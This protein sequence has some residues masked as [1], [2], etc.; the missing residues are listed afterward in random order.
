MHNDPGIC[1]L[2]WVGCVHS[3][4]VLSDTTSTSHTLNS[5]CYQINTLKHKIMSFN[6]YI[7]IVKYSLQNFG[8]D[9]RK[10]F[11]YFL[12]RKIKNQLSNPY[13]NLFKKW[14]SNLNVLFHIEIKVL[15]FSAESFRLGV[16]AIVPEINMTA[17]MYHFT[18]FLSILFKK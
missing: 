6:I 14:P 13:T 10:M 3:T 9:M 7:V 4:M 2:L 15:T 18:C 1:Q 5:K 12:F 11:S 8:T 17:T 16:L